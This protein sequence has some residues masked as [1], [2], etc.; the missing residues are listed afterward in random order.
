M[1]A[2]HQGATYAGHVL[3]SPSTRHIETSLYSSGISAV[4]IV[5]VMAENMYA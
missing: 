5:L 3:L 4:N 2:L 1:G